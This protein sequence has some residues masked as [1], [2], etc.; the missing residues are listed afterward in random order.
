MTPD[1]KEARE[2]AKSR[3]VDY[4]RA[5]RIGLPSRRGEEADYNVAK[6]L[7]SI[8]EGDVVVVPRERLEAF[9]ECWNGGDVR[10][11]HMYEWIK[12]IEELIATT[13]QGD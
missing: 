11:A 13:E 1:I 12:Y 6:A 2:I 8:L 4:E 9:I 3:I 10:M 5:K 7:L